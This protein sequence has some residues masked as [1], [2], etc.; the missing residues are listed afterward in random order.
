MANDES[1]AS[2]AQID[3]FVDA[4]DVRLACLERGSGPLVIVAHGFPDSV[5]SMAPLVETI[6]A[7]G[8]HAVAYAQRGYAP[9]S[10]PPG[11]RT[12]PVD[13]GRDILAIADAFGEERFTVVGHDWGAVAAH[14]VAQLAPER[15]ERYVAAG[16]PHTHTVIMKPSL[17][18]TWRSRYM[19]QFQVPHLPERLID[20]P[21]M[22]RIDALVRR[23]S[24]DWEPT[25]EQLATIRRG[26]EGPGRVRAAL[27]YYRG[28]PRIVIDRKT[29]HV[30]FAPVTVPAL[31]I[32]GSRDHC[33]GPE[34]FSTPGERFT[35]PV[36]AVT[37]DGCGHHMHLED[38]G[39]FAE[40]VL[41]HLQAS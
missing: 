19:L 41:G 33:M 34:R 1:V 5:Y 2:S 18:Q 32:C 40:H 26:L 8:F 12:T 10:L 27:G 24:P 36:Q 23:W 4:G 37:M 38:P 17:L 3:R 20:E 11:G 15:V 29:R 25:G 6:A 39:S 14:T 22:P 21:G 9:S 13:L 16:V 28:I 30:C 7:A 31:L 35:G